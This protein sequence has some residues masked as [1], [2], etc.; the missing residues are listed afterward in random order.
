VLTIDPS[1]SV[2]FG[3]NWIFV[4]DTGLDLLLGC[5]RYTPDRSCLAVDRR[6]CLSVDRKLAN[7]EI[8]IVEGQLKT[9][10]KVN[11]TKAG[12]AQFLL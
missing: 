11:M 12:P 10:D 1:D 2:V 4:S 7:P 5:F 9:F 8:I 6:L 3:F